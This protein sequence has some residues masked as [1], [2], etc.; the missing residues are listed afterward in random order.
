MT[1]AVLPT[2][3]HPA[4]L[5]SWGLWRGVL[6]AWV[7]ASSLVTS[8]LAHA[9]WFSAPTWPVLKQDIRL[10]YPEVRQ[11]S[12]SEF[13]VVSKSDRP[14][15]LL[16]VREREEFEVS[17]LQGARLATHL[18][19]ALGVLQAT[20]KDTPIVV[21]C[22]VGMRSSELASKLKQSGYTQVSNLEGSIFEWANAGLPVYRGNQLQTMVHP[23]SRKWSALLNEKLRSP[24]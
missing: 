18:S 24:L 1:H 23:F 12:I 3:G 9:Q 21:Y 15:V 7:V 8:G 11:M 6:A 10:K 22:S 4:A 16:D 20:P 2:I 14:P 13:Q 17:H 19:M 5:L